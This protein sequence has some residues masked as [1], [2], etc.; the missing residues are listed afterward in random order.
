[1]IPE[2]AQA[3]RELSQSGRLSPESE[4]NLSTILDN[5]D[6][7]HEDAEQKPAPAAKSTTPATK[8]GGSK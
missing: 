4:E 2:L 6:D 1:M 3:I 7:E 5:P 8:P